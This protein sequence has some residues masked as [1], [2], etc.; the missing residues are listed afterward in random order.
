MSYWGHYTS[1][2][3][4]CI[5][6]Y[7]YMYI[8]ICIYI[9]NQLHDMDVAFHR[10]IEGKPC[11]NHP[12]NRVFAPKQKVFRFRVDFPIIQSSKATYLRRSLVAIDV[13][14]LRQPPEPPVSMNQ[15]LFLR[16][17]HL[18]CWNDKYNFPDK[19]KS[20]RIYIYIILINIIHIIVCLRTWRC[21]VN[22]SI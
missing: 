9:Y 20:M 2:R 19:S 10:L 3:Y 16:C 8:Y 12:E 7:M 21:P 6:I 4:V 11:S 22:M 13:S 14:I 17:Q 15:G 1:S 5:Y 18:R